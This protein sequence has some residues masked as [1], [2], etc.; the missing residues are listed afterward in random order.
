MSTNTAIAQRLAPP[1]PVGGWRGWAGPIF[2]TVLAAILRLVNLGQPHAVVFDE[3]Y[4]AKDGLSLLLF[5]YERTSVEDANDLILASNGDPHQLLSIFNPDASY[6]VHPPLG[7]WIIASGIEFFGM[8]PWGW[9]IATAVVGILSVLILARIVRRLTRS[10]LLGTLAGLFLAIDG[11]GIVMSRTALLDN[12]LMFFVLIAFGCLLLDRDRTRKRLALLDPASYAE[13]KWGPKLGFRPWLLA[14]G[15]SL[16]LACG[17]KWSGLYF[18][19]GFGLLTVF[20][21][22]ST[23]RL[24]GIPNPW[25]ATLVRDALP[26]FLSMVGIGIVVYLATWWG[27][28]T[29]DSA[30]MHDWAASHGSTGGIFPEALRSLWHYHAEALSFHTSLASPH[31]YSANPW[32]WPVQGRPTSFSVINEGLDCGADKCRAHVLALGNPLIW[33]AGCLALVHQAWRWLA[34]R[35]WRS[36]AVICG[37]LAAWLPWLFFQQRTV[38]EFYSIVML[39]FMIMALTMSLGTILGSSHASPNRRK[40]GLISVGTFVMLVIAASWFFYP[41]WVGDPL[42]VSQWQLRMWLPSWI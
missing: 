10:N 7:K 12:S 36:G 38:F 42:S 21:D 23:R 18:V 34:N 27:W 1:L 40:W 22:I 20:W 13:R 2:V 15:I 24:I 19:A 28:F 14:A 11:L 4:Y 31:S 9:R 16:G 41:I 25:I 30:Y 35:D 29:N 8:N 17:V 37:F 26:A 33:W 5:G 6:V 32:L 3:T 39:P